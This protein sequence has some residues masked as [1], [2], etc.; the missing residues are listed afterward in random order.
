MLTRITYLGRLL[1]ELVYFSWTTRT[2]APALL[3]LAFLIL[4]VVIVF[5]QVSIPFIYTMF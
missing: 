1:V 5:T 3:V 2:L 4:G